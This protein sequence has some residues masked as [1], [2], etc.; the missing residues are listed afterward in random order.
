M[1]PETG[2]PLHIGFVVL[3]TGATLPVPEGQTYRGVD[4]LPHVPDP[5]EQLPD[6]VSEA[7]NNYL[8]AWED[9]LV[10]R[11]LRLAQNLA[12]GLTQAGEPAEV[13]YVDVMA[14]PSLTSPRV[15]FDR[16][17]DESLSW[18]VDRFA[19]VQAPSRDMVTLGL[20]VATAIPAFHSALRQPGL[21]EKDDRFR[22]SLNES[23]LV[24]NLDYAIELMN[25][26]NSSGYLLSTFAVLEIL[27]P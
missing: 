9:G 3:S 4:R 20:D 7:W 19:G 2:F 10:G 24:A 27:S 26:A 22:A 6:G 23:G 18:L 11:D 5:T 21:V 25:Q 16:Q 8:A 1:K 14:P 17:R 12:A 13:V 15:S